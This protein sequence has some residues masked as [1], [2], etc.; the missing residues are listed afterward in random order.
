MAYECGTKQAGRLL[1]F[2]YCFQGPL[3]ER[4]GAPP[5]TYA[6]QR[7]LEELGTRGRSFRY[8]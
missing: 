6:G 7:M 1:I 5:V 8:K 3:H 4:S 2:I